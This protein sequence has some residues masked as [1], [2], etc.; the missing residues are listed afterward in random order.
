MTR[1]R[2]RLY[3]LLLILTG[4]GSAT[5]LTLFALRD[6]ISYFR[7]PTDLVTGN[8][9]EKN[10]NRAFRL[11][12]LVEK[13][14]MKE[15]GGEITFRVSDLKNSFEVAFRG[16]PPDLFKEGQGVIAE[17]RL[18]PNGIFIANNL[19]A[20]HDEKYT[21]PEVRSELSDSNR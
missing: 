16:V 13:G 11:G 15:E 3:V 8:Y 2:A 10:G 9:A 6:N 18:G 12:G 20:K 14:S 21:P 1:R 7:T 4:I 17:G 5:G 19:L